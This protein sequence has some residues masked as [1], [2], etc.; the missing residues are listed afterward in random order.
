MYLYRMEV[1]LRDRSVQLVVMAETDE[2][3]FDSLEELIGRFYVK[4]PD[5]QSAA[6]IEKKRAVKGSGYV[7]D[8]GV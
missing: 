7:L 2:Q 5:V 4:T 6:I 8:P 1:E 3:A